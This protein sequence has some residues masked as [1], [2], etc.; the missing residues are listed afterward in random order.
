[1]AQVIYGN[2]FQGGL[3]RIPPSKSA[4]HRQ[5]LCAALS[6]GKCTLSH[7]DMSEDIQATVAAVEALGAKV[8][9]DEA[10]ATLTLDAANLG[11][12]NAAIDCR[13][14]GSTGRGRLPE[15][16][17]GV[18]GELL[19]AHGVEFRSQGGL[20]L[21]I[22]GKLKSGVYRMPGNVS[23]QFVTGLLFALP[24]LKG[25]SE[26]VLTSPLE[27]KGYVALTLSILREYG[28]TAQEG[29]T[30][31]PPRRRP[32]AGT[33]P[34]ASAIPPTTARWRAT[35]PRRPFSCAWRRCPPQGR[36]W[37]SRGW[38]RPPSRGTRPAWS[39]SAS[40]ACRFPGR[41]VSSPPA[42]PG[43]VS[44]LAACGASPST[45]PRFPTWCRPCPSAPP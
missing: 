33:S 22:S 12:Q 21:E 9:F 2:Q 14:S 29:S 25:D 1:M 35:G 24:L 5:V 44:P 10:A 8:S 18:Y 32:R 11:R 4:A 40:S 15:R 42:T 39:C 16:P 23:S 20:P 3:V 6:R 45:P 26:I 30:A 7:V 13:E 37:P 17:L 43:P 34:A 28:V 41:A 38:T 27:S 19:P 31:S 36:R